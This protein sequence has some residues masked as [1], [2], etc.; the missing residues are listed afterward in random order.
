MMK[1]SKF[2]SPIIIKEYDTQWPILFENEKE[3]INKVIGEYILSIEHIGSTS[4]PGLGS[5]PIIDIMIGVSKF[6]DSRKCITPLKTLGYSYV[7]EFE[8]EIPGRR[9]FRKGTRADATHHIHLVEKDGKF[10]I[11]HLLFRDYLRT[12]PESAKEYYLLKK[13]LAKKFVND[14]DGYVNAKS[15]FIISIVEKAKHQ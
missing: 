12:H 15:E 13:E 6:E 3:I 11:D 7:P 2:K 4:V 8:A 5:K 9:F 14:R 1:N 10:W